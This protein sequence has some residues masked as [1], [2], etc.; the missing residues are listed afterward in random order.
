MPQLPAQEASPTTAL[1]IPFSSLGI[2]SFSVGLATVHG[3]SLQ[4]R[5][6]HCAQIIVS[7]NPWKNPIRDRVQ[8][9]DVEHA[10]Q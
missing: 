7:S 6:P 1:Q 3:T 2:A 9:I 8:E 4:S 10:A 5:R